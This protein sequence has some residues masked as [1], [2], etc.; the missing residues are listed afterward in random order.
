MN[1]NVCS[2]GIFVLPFIGR[3]IAAV[4]NFEPVPFQDETHATI[5][6]V[7][8]RETTDNNIVFVEDDFVVG[9]IRKLI[10]FKLAAPEINNARSRSDI[11][12]VHL[13]HFFCIA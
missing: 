12:G 2:P 7:Y 10:E 6:C 9:L 11:P 13:L 1:G 3:R 5:E 4:N 8:G